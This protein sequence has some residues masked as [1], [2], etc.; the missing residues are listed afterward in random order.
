M[1]INGILIR[2]DEELLAPGATDWYLSARL[3]VVRKRPA[4]RQPRPRRRRRRLTKPLEKMMEAPQPMMR[5][6][7]DCSLINGSAS[8]F[9]FFNV[10][11]SPV[12]FSFRFSCLASSFP[13]SPPLPA[14]QLTN[15]T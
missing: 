15:N 13:F 4:Q 1:R 3:C 9:G 7:S 2:T 10:F 8:S 14:R 12:R 11:F 6:S 5:I